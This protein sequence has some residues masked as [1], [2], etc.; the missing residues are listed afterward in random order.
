MIAPPTKK[1][2]SGNK[3]ARDILKIRDL[4]LFFPKDDSKWRFSIDFETSRFPQSGFFI[5]IS[6]I[7]GFSGFF[8]LVKNEKSRSFILRTGIRNSKFRKKSYHEAD[9]DKYCSTP[10]L[11]DGIPFEFECSSWKPSFMFYSKIQLMKD[12]C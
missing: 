1:S 9:D 10:R 3:K 7:F 12:V 6:K 8:D 2:R 4:D 11:S 5:P